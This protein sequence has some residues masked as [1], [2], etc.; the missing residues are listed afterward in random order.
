[1]KSLLRAL[2][3]IF[4]FILPAE[5]SDWVQVT[6]TP[7]GD[8]YFVDQESIVRVEENVRAMTKHVLREPMQV[9]EGSIHS[10]QSY[11]EYGCEQRRMRRTSLQAYD[12]NEEKIHWHYSPLRGDSPEISISWRHIQPGTVKQEIFRFLC[13]TR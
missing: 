9:N 1:M 13:N 5:G 4:L 3:C 6:H 12:G 8:T 11:E 2:V 7:G 10:T